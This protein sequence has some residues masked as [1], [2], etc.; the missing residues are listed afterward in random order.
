MTA[1]SMFAATV[2]LVHLEALMLETCSDFRLD[3]GGFAPTNDS[4]T[5]HDAGGYSVHNTQTKM[6]MPARLTLADLCP[7][8]ALNEQWLPGIGVARKRLLFTWCRE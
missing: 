7:Y 5:L 3:G 6:R 2:G 4:I 1:S 8:K